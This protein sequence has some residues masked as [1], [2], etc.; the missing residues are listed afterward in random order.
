M[1]PLFDEFL[2][3]SEAVG[4][5]REWIADASAAAVAYYQKPEQGRALLTANCFGGRSIGHF[6]FYQIGA[7]LRDGSSTSR[8]FGKAL[9]GRGYRRIETKLWNNRP[10]YWHA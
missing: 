7:A 6:D 3:D 2:E 10:A 1:T 9:R 8:V 4:L 5:D